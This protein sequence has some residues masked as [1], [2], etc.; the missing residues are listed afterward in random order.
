MR[1]RGHV[2]QKRVRGQGEIRTLG[3][4]TCTAQET[5]GTWTS[6]EDKLK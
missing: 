6:Q 2:S 1:K 4:R 3:Q 5:K